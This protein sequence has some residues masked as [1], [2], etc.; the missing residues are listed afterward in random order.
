MTRSGLATGSIISIA[1]IAAGLVSTRYVDRH[2]ATAT[3]KERSSDS[4]RAARSPQP[5]TSSGACVDADGSWKNWPWA[6]VP[7]LS[8]KCK[9]DQ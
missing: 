2:F 9:P 8:P 1:V 4:P 7:M 6:N 5:S 3:G